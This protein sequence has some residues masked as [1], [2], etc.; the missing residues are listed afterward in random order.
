M[1]ALESHRSEEMERA[2]AALRAN[3]LDFALL[4][5]VPNITYLSGWEVPPA[6]GPIADF[7]GGLP[8]ALVLVSARDE[9]GWLLLPD[10]LAAPASRK[11]RLDHLETFGAFGHFEAVEVAETFSEMLRT[12]LRTAGLDG[13]RAVLGMERHSLPAVAHWLVTEEFS[14][15]ELR[16]AV[17]SLEE[18][19]R[20]KTPREIDLLRRAIAVADAAQN[21][22]LE[23]SARSGDSDLDVWDELVGRMEREVGH[24]L[25]VT[26]ELVTGPRTSTVAPGGP[27]GRQIERGDTGLLDISPRV[28]GYWADCTN[29]VVFDAEPTQQQRRYFTA[30]REACEAAAAS[31]YP[32]TRCC[33]VEAVVRSTLEKHGFP[34]AHYSGHQLGAGVNEKPRLVQYDTSVIEPGMIFAIEPG[35]YAGD[36][37]STGARAEKA[38]LVTESGPEVLSQ[39]SWGM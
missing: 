4:S 10:M 18:A 33:D 27:V 9:A 16:N 24:P 15:V 38:V 17:P 34:V 30:A 5:S 19:R 25:V 32:G 21:C 6:I 1:S 14:N 37:G 13:T 3:G 20:I 26:G 23:C 22:L 35:V 29:T 11:N 39:F 8:F 28:D 2:C 31:L 7:T 12:V 36:G